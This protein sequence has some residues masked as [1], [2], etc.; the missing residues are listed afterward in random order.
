M[1]TVVSTHFDDA[2]FSCWTVLTGDADVEVLTVFTAGPDDDR[3]TEWDADTGVTSAERMVQ[4]AAENSAALELAGRRA[5]NLGLR[6]GQYDGG[7]VDPAVLREPLSHADVVYVPAG[8]GS[9]H[10]NLEHAVVREA[11]LSV[12]PNAFVYADNPYWHFRDDATLP[13]GLELGLRRMVVELTPT[14]RAQKADAIAC[15]AGEL[16]K[17]E[18]FFGPCTDPA[19]LQYEVFWESAER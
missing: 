8:S 2:V 10:A 6:E 18:A 14:Q 1:I 17:L 4:R 15:Y 3:V 16:M 12:C 19:R 11:C 9:K 5:V 7:K 13:P